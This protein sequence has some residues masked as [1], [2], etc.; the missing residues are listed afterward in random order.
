MYEPL[1][2]ALATAARIAS[3]R[4][5]PP[6]IKAIGDDIEQLTDVPRR[7][8]W[9]RKAAR[10]AAIFGLLADAVD[11]PVAAGVLK[12]GNTVVRD[13]AVSAGPGADSMIISSHRRLLAHLR[14][15]DADAA[16]YE[17]V[18]LLSCLHYMGRL[19]RLAGRHRARC[20]AG[21][22]RVGA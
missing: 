6:H 4:L 2:P 13:L 14:A 20:S 7:P 12:L 18:R 1:I 11:D 16:E 22:S 3:V 15:A 17:I 8:N 10:H 19:A 5:A 9:E 21:P